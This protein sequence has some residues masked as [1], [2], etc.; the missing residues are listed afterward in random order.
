MKYKIQQAMHFSAFLTAGMTLL[1]MWGWS[2]KIIAQL[3]T[4]DKFSWVIGV[5]LGILLT[6]FIG[7]IGHL[8][9]NIIVDWA[10]RA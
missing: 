4:D 1:S 6:G 8:I 3:I 5:P 7:F 9:I 10:D 2:I